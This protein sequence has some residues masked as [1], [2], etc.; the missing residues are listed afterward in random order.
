MSTK[1]FLLLLVTVIAI[2]GSIGGAFA[3][4]L[5]LGRSQDDDA[6]L[7]TAGFQQRL[8]G[9]QA[10][11]G[12]LQFGGA[13]PGGA[14]TGE[15]AQ[16]GQVAP[17]GFGGGGFGGGGGAGGGF[18]RNI[19][20]GIISAVDGNLI[21]IATDLGETRVVLGDDST[22]QTFEAG[23]VADLSLGD[24]IFVI[25]TGDIESEEPVEAA[26]VIVNQP[27][28]AGNFGGGGF[29]GRGFLNGTVGAVDGALLTVATDSGE[30]RVNLG[31]G[32]TIQLYEAG[33][34]GDLTAGDRVL[35]IITGDLSAGEP[36]IAASVTINPPEG[37]GL[38]GAGGFGERFGDRPRRP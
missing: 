2:G 20:N 11:S 12:N 16:T 25:Y 24:R 38:F 3:G 22:V 8:G 32:L 5:A 17:Q 18:S 28:G 15:G 10:P 35:V 37:G 30:T 13:P 33:T 4:G 14:L 34:T 26:S 7:E 27:Q 31:E 23:T 9:G 21:T 29:G 6:T 19:V 1:G 36:A